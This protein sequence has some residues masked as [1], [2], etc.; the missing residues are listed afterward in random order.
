MCKM[1]LLLK[2]MYNGRDFMGYQYQPDVRTVQGTL[3]SAVSSCF[4]REMKITGC[5]R[6]DAGVHALGFCCTAEPAGE[7]ADGWLRIPVGK[8]HR[9][10]SRF[11]PEDIAVAGESEAADDFHPRYSV[12]SKE[13]IY[14]MYD[15]VGTDPFLNGRAWHLKHPVASEGLVRMNE[16]ARA[17]IGSHDFTS[18]MASGS[19]IEDARRTIES[20]SVTRDGSM[21][22]LRVRADGFLYNMVRIITG[23]LADCAYGTID[24]AE[25]GRI[26]EKRDRCA[27]GKTAPADGL[28]LNDV[29]YGFPIDWKL[30]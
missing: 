22:T 29:T 3:T 9:A 15:T 27:A 16:G 10:L 4:G 11:L 14:R 8:V 28:Y 7:Y 13:Y 17:L 1:K 20:L 26:L 24:P 25:L 5:S 19:K 30:Y 21:L 2:I 18:F 12:V 6:T 23:T